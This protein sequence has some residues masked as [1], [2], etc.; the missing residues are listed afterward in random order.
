MEKITL[1]I[2]GMMCP[3]C[4]AHMN[5]AIR[6]GF[7]I[8]KVVSSHKDKQTIILTEAKITDEQLKATVEKTGYKLLGITRAPYE[9]KGILSILKKK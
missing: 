9:K 7:D 1:K 5:D 8:K 4:E 3:M 2:E 6:N